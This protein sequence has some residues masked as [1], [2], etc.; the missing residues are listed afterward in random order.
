[1]IGRPRSEQGMDILNIILCLSTLSI[2]V[3]VIFQHLMN[4]IFREFLDNFVVC[5]LNNILIFSKNEKDHKKHIMMEL[6]KL[7]NAGL[8]IK[9][10]KYIFHQPQVKFLDYIISREGLPMGLK[11]I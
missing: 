11:K 1:M 9:M 10:E 7:C 5:Y 6:Q 2:E 8:S 4:D 3:L